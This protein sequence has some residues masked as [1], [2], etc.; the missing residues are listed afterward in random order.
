MEASRGQSLRAIGGVALPA[1][2]AALGG[3]LALLIVVGVG[4]AIV[5]SSPILV[6]AI[7]FLL[8]GTLVFARFPAVPVVGAVLITAIVGTTTSYLAVIPSVRLAEVTLLCLWLGT[9]GVFLTNRGGVRSHPLPGT[10]LIALFILTGVG[11]L[12]LN[13]NSAGFESFRLSTLF[14]ISVPVLSIAPWSLDT[15]RTMARGIVAVIALVAG[16]CALRYAIG[17]SAD[18]IANARATQPGLPFSEELRFFGS[19]QSAQELSGWC[20]VVLPFVLA[21]A[22]YLRRGWRLLAVAAVG[23]CALALLASDVRTGVAAAAAGI[24]V[25]LTLFALARAY[26]SGKRVLTTGLLTLGLLVAGVGGYLVTVASSPESSARFEGLLDPGDDPGFEIRQQRWDAAWDEVIDEPLGHGL[27]TTG[28]AAFRRSD[29][30]PVGPNPLDSS[31]LKV[32]I[33]QGPIVMVLFVLILLVA[34]AGLAFRTIS[35]DSQ[36]RATLGIAAGGTLTSMIVLFYGSLYSELPSVVVAGW[37]IVGLGTTALS[38]F[39]VGERP[40]PSQRQL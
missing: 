6:F 10:A 24:G 32:G 12:G 11:W 2:I 19:F 4:L 3:A 29:V 17:S 34:L 18:E 16:Y 15:L 40:A 13:S 22:I 1:A 39:P 20:A 21:L 25:T 33:E 23:L 28:A 26:P 38:V 35:T 27:G 9:I 37:L 7:P 8:V 36:L 14:L 30:L 31:Y 5:F